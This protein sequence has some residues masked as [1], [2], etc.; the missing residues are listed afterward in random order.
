M[1]VTLAHRIV[2]IDRKL[3]EVRK[4][5]EW[6]DSH[7]LFSDAVMDK[8]GNNLLSSIL[9]ALGVPRKEL[10]L[11]LKRHILAD[12]DARIN[13]LEKDLRALTKDAT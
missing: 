2:A 5:R 11:S 7:E 4:A 13:A 9:G 6:A 10:A 3:A 12:M 8:I 1:N